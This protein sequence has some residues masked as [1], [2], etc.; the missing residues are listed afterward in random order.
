[1]AKCYQIPADGFATTQLLSHSGTSGANTSST[2]VD[3]A[4][5]DLPLR[6]L[7]Q[8]VVKVVQF[9]NQ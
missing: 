4:L 9:L 5:E 8:E 3:V 1:M 7:E 2:D 6:L